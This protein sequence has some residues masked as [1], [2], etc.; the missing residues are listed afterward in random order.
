VVR[1][2]PEHFDLDNQ[3]GGGGYLVKSVGGYVVG[4]VRNMELAGYCADWDGEELQVK[5]SNSSS[6]QYDILTAN[7]F[8]RRGESSYRATCFPAA[9][10]LPKGTPGQQPGCSLAGSRELACG[11]ESPSFLA[12]V[13][14]ALDQLIKD[15][16]GLFDAG[17]NQAGTNFIKVLDVK[18]YTDGMVELLKGKG[19]CA[20]WDGE[21]IQVKREN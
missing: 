2:H 5:D 15:K 12:D 8:I 6:D 1:E 3:L 13:E 11:R 10:P 21:E 7:G 18:G 20:R 14:A 9:F 16:P 17:D 4:V 19:Y